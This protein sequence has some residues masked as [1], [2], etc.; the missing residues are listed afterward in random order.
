MAEEGKTPGNG[1]ASPFGDS[2]GSTMADGP[3]DGA[4][5]FLEDPTGG[6]KAGGRDFTKENRPQVP[7]DPEDRY[8]ASSVPD[9]G[10]LPFG[11][12]DDGGAGERDMQI[13]QVVDQTYP[14][15]PFKLM[16]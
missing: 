13:S 5:N 1:Y 16:G 15:K 11:S 4:H 10:D 7:C 3:D 12:I 9:G 2:K 14:Q 6:V 8:N